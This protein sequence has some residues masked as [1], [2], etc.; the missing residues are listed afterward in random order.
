MR[1]LIP[2]IRLSWHGGV[3]ILIDVANRL[4]ASGNDVTFLV[5]RGRVTTPFRISPGVRVRHIG[6]HTPWKSLDYFVFLAALPFFLSSR[7]FVI[8]NFF[9]TYFPVRLASIV[10]RTRYLY[11]VQD[12]ESKYAGA[13]G[14]LL[15]RLCDWTYRDQR[16]VAGNAHLQQRLQIEFGTTCR[17]IDIGPDDVFYGPRTVLAKEFDVVFFL[18]KEP[19]KGLERFERFLA[20]ANGLFSCLCV[21]QDDQLVR[22]F[23][24]PAVTCRKPANDSELVACLD[25]ARVLLFT[26]HHEGFA[27]PPLEAMARGL[28]VV[29]YRCG[30]PDLYVAD[31]RNAFYVENESDMCHAVTRLIGDPEIYRQMSAQASMTAARFRMQTA[32]SALLGY[33][34]A[35][36][37]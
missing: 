32:A 27:L 34:Q 35:L 15:N 11:F 20:T 36:S 9:V 7:A 19:W 6:I 17:S 22:S 23:S 28:P 33:A 25:S 37:D 31:G 16:I 26:S 12:I 8:A 29:L 30:G 24:H 4:A 10:R 14:A 21:S 13:A 18:R 3:R 5:S 2:V 1:I